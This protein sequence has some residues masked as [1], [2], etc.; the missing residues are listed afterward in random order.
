M[1]S[2][3]LGRDAKGVAGIILLLVLEGRMFDYENADEEEE[4]FR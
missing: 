1:Q 4:R 3:A 2:G